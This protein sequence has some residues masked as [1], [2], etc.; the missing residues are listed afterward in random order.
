MSLRSIWRIETMKNTKGKSNNIKYGSIYSELGLDIESKD[1]SFQK[2]TEK[3]KP[4]I[5]KILDYWKSEKYIKDYQ[6]YKEGRSFKGIEII[7]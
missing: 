7:Y 3:L 4:S 2:K 1:K 5:K 6:E